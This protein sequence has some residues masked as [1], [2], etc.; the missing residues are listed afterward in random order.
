MHYIASIVPLLQNNENIALN[1]RFI[2]DE[3][4]EAVEM[5]QKITFTTKPKAKFEVPLSEG[6]QLYSAILDERISIE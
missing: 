1:D 4:V 5:P 2:R 3:F 6:Y